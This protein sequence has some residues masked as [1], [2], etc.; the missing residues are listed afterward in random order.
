MP[1]QKKIVI[2]MAG[3]MDAVT[4]EMIAMADKLMA[5]VFMARL[6]EAEEVFENLML[7]VAFADPKVLTDTLWMPTTIEPNCTV[8]DYIALAKQRLCHP[9]HETDLKPCH[10][11]CCDRHGQPHFEDGNCED[12]S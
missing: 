1:E 3:A 7:A 9:D 6:K 4:P 8:L 11:E 2:D 5:D 10:D 12:G